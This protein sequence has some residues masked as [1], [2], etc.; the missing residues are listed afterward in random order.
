MFVQSKMGGMP[1]IVAPPENIGLHHSLP[2]IMQLDAGYQDTI[3][4][5]DWNGAS[6]IIADQNT[7]TQKFKEAIL[8][9]AVNH[10][11]NRNRGVKVPG[12]WW[13]LSP[14][15]QNLP[16]LSFKASTHLSELTGPGP[17]L[18]LEIRG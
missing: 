2:L 15:R 1:D 8:I 5:I 3:H 14:K 4:S 17:S 12:I 10:G 16:R 13:P 6:V 9:K 11:L 18:V 7:F